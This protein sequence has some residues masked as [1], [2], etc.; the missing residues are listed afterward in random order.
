M[1]RFQPSPR[2]PLIPFHGDSQGSGATVLLLE[3]LHRFSSSVELIQAVARQAIT[4]KHNRAFIVVL[5]PVPQIPK[6]AHHTKSGLVSIHRGPESFQQLGSLDNLKA[7]CLRAMCRQGE[8][9]VSNRPRGALLG[10][11]VGQ[12]ESNVR[13]ALKLA[14]AMAPCVLFADEIEKALGQSYEFGP[15]GLGRNGPR[16]R[17]AAHVA[18]RP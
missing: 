18:E 15:I 8:G 17:L 14:D 16:I 4:A 1:H 2:Q 13:A 12:S 9:T 10:S 7:F 3:N 6:A 11:L 5:T